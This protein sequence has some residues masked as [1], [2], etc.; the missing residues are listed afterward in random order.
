MLA[1]SRQ[2]DFAVYMMLHVVGAVAGGAEC[3]AAVGAVHSAEASHLQCWGD[4]RTQGRARRSL[5]HCGVWLLRSPWGLWPGKQVSPF[6]LNHNSRGHKIGCTHHVDDHN[7]CVHALI[8]A[9]IATMKCWRIVSLWTRSAS[10]TGAL[11]LWLQE[12]M[13]LGPTMYFGEL[14]LLRGEPRAATVVAFTDT[15]VLMLARE[16]FNILLG[17]LQLLLGQN[18]TLYGP[19]ATGPGI[20]QASTVPQ[21]PVLLW[22]MTRLIRGGGGGAGV[23]QWDVTIGCVNFDIC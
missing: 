1:V 10:C 14:A 20:K 11:C 18:A 22:S 19:T 15:S 9:A 21:C 4:D 2:S 13:R 7:R 6:L 8:S 16:D 5:L 12:V 23:C 3:I 17:P